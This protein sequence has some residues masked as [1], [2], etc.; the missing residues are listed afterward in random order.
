MSSRKITLFYAVL[1]ALASLA[2]GMVIA[3]RLDLAPRIVG[4]DAGGAA[5][6]QRAAPGRLTRHVPEHRQGPGRSS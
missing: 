1:I 2:V 4:P 6:E 5:H 3:S